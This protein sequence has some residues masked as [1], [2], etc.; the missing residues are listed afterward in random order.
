MRHRPDSLV[1]VGSAGHSF[2]APREKRGAE[3]REPRRLCE[4]LLGALAKHARHTLR[5]R[6]PVP[7]RSATGRLSAL[8]CGVLPYGTGPALSAHRVVLPPA[9]LLRGLLSVRRGAL[10][11]AAAR[12]LKPPRLPSLKADLGGSAVSQ[13]LAGG[14]SAPGRSPAPPEGGVTNPARGRRIPLRPRRVSG[15]RPS[16]SGMWR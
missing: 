9:R 10:R 16:T 1:G 8:R 11:V 13:L 4:S 14:R 2:F 12:P 3:R 5:E 6:V 7:L 15:R